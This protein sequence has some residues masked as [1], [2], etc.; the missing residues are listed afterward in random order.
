MNNCSEQLDLLSD[1]AL[2]CN[3]TLSTS[4]GGLDLLSDVVALSCNMALSTS[5]GGLDLL[6]NA[7]AKFF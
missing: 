1:V 7:F 2:S 6:S 5:W 4:R 3:M